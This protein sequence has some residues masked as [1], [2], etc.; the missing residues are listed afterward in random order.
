MLGPYRESVSF[1]ADPLPR[2]C[3]PAG[4]APPCPRNPP[5]VRGLP[6]RYAAILS[7]ATLLVVSLAAPVTVAWAVLWARNA[8]PVQIPARLP[9]WASTHDVDAIWDRAQQ[10]AARGSWLTLARA[11]VAPGAFSAGR[12]GSFEHRVHVAHEPRGLRLMEL[13]EGSPETLLGLRAGDLVTAINGYALRRP[14]EA[15]RAYH[16]VA[17]G[18]GIVVELLRE[19]KPVAL[20]VDWSRQERMR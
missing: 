8:A 10:K 6:D 1:V 7:A 16:E 17:A 4:S 15:F 5:P 11:T 12:R 3:V 18:R 19:G 9:R 2:T 13:Q 20:R 14:T